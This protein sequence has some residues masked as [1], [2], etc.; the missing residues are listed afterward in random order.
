[1]GDE[2]EASSPSS[3]PFCIF[4]CNP[5]SW[6][7]VADSPVFAF[8]KD[9][10]HKSDHLFFASETRL[11][12]VRAAE[13][14]SRLRQAGWRSLWSPAT[15][16]GNSSHGTHGGTVV[17][18][19]SH[20]HTA[21]VDQKLAQASGDLSGVGEHWTFCTLWL[22]HDVQ[23]EVGQIYLEDSVGLN[24]DNR[25]RLVRARQYLQM[26]GNPF[27]LAGDYNMSP[28]KLA[29]GGI[30]DMFGATI[31]APTNVQATCL[32][33]SGTMDDYVL[34]SNNI[35]DAVLAVLASRECPWGPHLG[36]RIFIHR[37]PRA[38]Q[39]KQLVVPKPIAE[40]IKSFP[41]KSLPTISDNAWHR[42]QAIV[43][44]SE[45]RFVCDH[46]HAHTCQDSLHSSLFVASESISQKLFQ[47]SRVFEQ[48]YLLD[49]VCATGD[50]E[51]VS[52]E[53]PPIR[54]AAPTF[55]TVPL[56]P[57]KDSSALSHSN[58]YVWYWSKMHARL[59]EVRTF[60]GRD[61]R[62]LPQAWA[63]LARHFQNLIILPSL[64]AVHGLKVHGYDG[65]QDVEHADMRTADPSTC[66]TPEVD[67]ATEFAQA[68]YYLWR[69]YEYNMD[70]WSYDDLEFFWNR[71]DW[72]RSVA[73]RAAKSAKSRDFKKWLAES[74]K[75]GAKKAHAYTNRGN[76][77]T[78]IAE[79]IATDQ[80]VACTPLSTMA[81]RTATW[82]KLW[83][84]DSDHISSVK[85]KFS[86]TSLTRFGARF[87][88]SMGGRAGCESHP[89][90]LH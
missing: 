7:P 46:S 17:C 58:R 63:A 9:S 80:G 64:L 3:R 47:W 57:R 25:S 62:Q 67:V 34:V 30:P 68:E 24:E 54:G 12:A 84:R 29:E 36:I 66:V 23:I 90:A 18:S 76:T 4:S 51:Q 81:I 50:T 39:I 14:R 86:Q 20:L 13:A 42:A 28:T 19:R 61:T 22:R 85:E 77:T 37:S 49:P 16:T 78:A 69:T 26:R 32:Q 53:A 52:E 41:A 48:A 5:N 59:G 38:L 6:G 11:T 2:G 21:M 88:R 89:R 72:L 45:Q 31:R 82:S 8:M 60:W 1:M 43:A 35:N 40:N 70:N 73:L 55:R 15:L 33:G 44:S 74:L 27:I 10:L 71:A 75:N 87:S 65:L 56:V 83:R 79:D